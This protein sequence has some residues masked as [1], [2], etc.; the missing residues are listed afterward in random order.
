MII[1]EKEQSIIR[2]I[3]Q[4]LTNK[5]IGSHLGISENTVK[6]RITILNQ[7]LGSSDRKNLHRNYIFHTLTKEPLV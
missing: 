6:S 7:K 1:T 5:E 2:L 4:G 3:G